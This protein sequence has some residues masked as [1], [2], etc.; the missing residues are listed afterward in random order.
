MRVYAT[1]LGVLLTA[2]S[3]FLAHVAVGSAG[4]ERLAGPDPQPAV[5]TF[6]EI[7]YGG[8]LDPVTIEVARSTRPAIALGVPWMTT[9]ELAASQKAV[10]CARL[11]RLKPHTI[12]SGNARASLGSMM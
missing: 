4:F 8:V 2:G 11:A 9:S 5:P 7:W 3:G 6:G 1:L 10:E 12:T